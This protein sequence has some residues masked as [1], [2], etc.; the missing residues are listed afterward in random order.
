MPRIVY[1]TGKDFKDD[2]VTNTDLL[3]RLDIFSEE[4]STIGRKLIS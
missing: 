2:K 1:A 4:F 3:E